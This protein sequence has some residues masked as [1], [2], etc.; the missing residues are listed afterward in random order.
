VICGAGVVLYSLVAS[1][2]EHLETII[3]RAPVAVR[4]MIDSLTDYCSV[5]ELRRRTREHFAELDLVAC[6]TVSRIAID[7]VGAPAMGVNDWTPVAAPLVGDSVLALLMGD[8]DADA[9]DKAG[10]AALLKTLSQAKPRLFAADDGPL[11]TWKEPLYPAYVA[12]DVIWSTVVLK[13]SDGCLAQLPKVA[14]AADEAHSLWTTFQVA[15][16]ILPAQAAHIVDKA[17]RAG[18]F[19]AIV[20][21][22]LVG[23]TLTSSGAP[24]DAGSI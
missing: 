5:E 11:P 13:M 14:G 24:P 21:T 20:R 7:H 9:K 3:D 19:E 6:S 12:G 4:L 10:M 17:M 15:W 22:M 8:T 16:T 1:G 2:T 23:K 18:F